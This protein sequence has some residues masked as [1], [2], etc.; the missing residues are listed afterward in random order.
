MHSRAPSAA[1]QCYDRGPSTL[2]RAGGDNPRGGGHVVTTGYL[3]RDAQVGGLK[4]HYQEWG[5]SEAPVM[6]ML[7]GFGVSGHMFDEFAERM[8]DRYRLVAL[9]QRGHGDSDWSAEGDYSREAFVNDVEGFR[10]ALGLER[11]VLVGHSMGGLNAVSYAVR[12]P[13]QVKALVLVDVG[14][15]AAKEGVDN[16]VRFTRGPDELEFDEFVEMAYRFNPRRSLENIRERMRHRLRPSESGKWTWKFDRR[17][18]EQE[19]GL[20][21]GSELTSDQV[22]QLYRDVQSPTL[23][24]RGGESDVLTQEV[25]ERAAREMRRARLVTVPGAGHSV[26]G[27]NP[28]GFTAEVASFLDDLETGRF[29]PA[30]AAEPP[31]LEQL[32]EVHAEAAARRR[33]PG[34][35]TLVAIGAGLALALA[36]AGMLARRSAQQGRRVAVPPVREQPPE[37][38]AAELERA[39]QRAAEL[40]TELTVL[41]RERL[42]QAKSALAEVDLERAR[43]GAFDVVHALAGPAGQARA[44]LREHLPARPARVPKRGVARTSLAVAR[45]APLLLGRRRR[46]VRRRGLGARLLAW[47]S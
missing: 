1:G 36:A 19:S 37:S 4:L 22:W 32:L 5:A 16:I 26:P 25:A 40:A 45:T 18:R 14:P 29:A 13:E 11:F 12:H 41:S 33:R 8:Q 35:L 38:R 3:E 2:P 20:R 28:D 43:V 21:V 6:L 27:D 9:D 15:E 17:F 34:T 47:R 7:H 23:L 46:R 44:A 31:P 24:V 39:R 42:Q 30:A 10:L